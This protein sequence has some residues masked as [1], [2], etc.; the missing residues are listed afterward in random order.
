MFWLSVGVLFIASFSTG[1]VWGYFK[2][3]VDME[4]LEEF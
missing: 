3:K 4:E 2:Y 1:F